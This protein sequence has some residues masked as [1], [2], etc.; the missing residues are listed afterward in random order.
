MKQVK[1][2]SPR[3]SYPKEKGKSFITN[4]Q[5]QKSF[6]PSPSYYNTDK[7]FNIITIGARRGYK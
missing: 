2:S 5:K 7:A 4:Y 6:V 1:T 3:F